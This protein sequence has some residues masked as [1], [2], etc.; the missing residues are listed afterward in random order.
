MAA[1]SRLYEAKLIRIDSGTETLTSTDLGRV[2]AKYYIDWQT[3]EKFAATLKPMMTDAELLEVFGMSKEFQQLKVREEEQGELE[4][5]WIDKQ[6]CPVQARGGASTIQGKVAIL[7]QA[8]I[9]NVGQFEATSLTSDLNYITQSASRLF[10]AMFD[11]TLTRTVRMSGLAEKVLEWCKC[12]DMRLWDPPYHHILRHF[13]QPPNIGNDR[14]AGYEAKKGGVLKDWAVQKLEERGF[15][16][17]RIRDDRMTEGELANV[18]GVPIAAQTVL[19]YVKRV[20]YLNTKVKLQPITGNIVRIV[21]QLTA[22]FEWSD[23]YS[24]FSEP[25]HIWVV[26]PSSEDL[27]HYETFVLTKKARNDLH[28]LSFIV[29]LNEPR[30]PQYIVQVVSDRWVGLT[31]EEAFKVSHLM[32]PDQDSQHTELLDLTPLPKRALKNPAYEAIYPRFTHFNAIQT[33][34]FHT[35]YHTDFNVLVG[36]PTGSGK[37]IISELAM[38]RLFNCTPTQ[39]VVYIA[40]LKAL[41]KERMIDWRDRLVKGL[42]KKVV[43]LTGDFTP[44]LK[45]LEEADVVV[46]T[47]EKFDGIS[48]NWKTRDYVKRTGLIIID[49]I[50]LLG[51]DRGPVL[52]VIVSRMRFMASQLSQPIR[53]VGLSTALANAPDIADW[54]GIGAVGL[55][56]FKPAV[57]PVPMTCH[58]QGYP[59]KHYCPRMATMN[60]PCLTAIKNHSA[61]KPVLI[62]VSSRR[63]TRITAFDLI[64]HM[65]QDDQMR[66]LVE[67]GNPPWIHMP[68]DEV[69]LWVDKAH[70]S[71]LKHCLGFGVGM[72]HAGLSENDRSLV[73][74]LFAC[75]KIQILIATSTLAWGVN[76][77]AH[78]VIV[79]GTEY[80]DGDTKRYVDMAITDVLQMIGRAGR[81]QFDDNAV[82]VVMVHEPKKAFYRKFLYS[83]FPVESS[84]HL[85]LADHLNAEIALGTVLDLKQAVQ[86]LSWTY[87]FRRLSANPSYY[88]CT[89][90]DS[91]REAM[92]KYFEA[93]LLDSLEQLRKSGCITMTAAHLA[94]GEVVPLTFASTYLGKI[95]ST[96]YLSHQS[97]RAFTRVMSSGTLAFAE[98]LKLLADCHEYRNV[99]VRHNEDKMNEELAQRVPLKVHNFESPHTK[100]LL[101]L[102]CHL[103]RLKLPIEDYQTDTKNIL[104]Q[105]IRVIQ[106]MIDVAALH[107]HAKTAENLILLLQCIQQAVH[108]WQDPL[109][110][111]PGL[112][113]ESIA[114]LS[115][116]TLASLVEDHY[117]PGLSRVSKGTAASVIDHVRKL[118][119]LSV[120]SSIQQARTVEVTLTLDNSP[121]E[122]AV[123]PK[124][125]KLKTVSW[126]VGLKSIDG[127]L[128]AIRK[129][130]MSSKKGTSRQVKID[131]VDDSSRAGLKVFVAPDSYV[132]LDQEMIVS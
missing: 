85:C 23:R 22:D 130:M 75:G 24:G 79:K 6:I 131:L 69:S 15:D 59:E 30:P 25:F 88:N 67:F 33:Q 101:L 113:S 104:D 122:Y 107:G 65:A 83:P 124:F 60:K 93:L 106:A 57:R 21:L 117:H 70:D 96:Y 10:R 20:P 100:A 51:A 129:V 97:V 80:Y 41:S 62:F 71:N 4:S 37:T 39:K 109:F 105:S 34:V 54:L 123:C 91:S 35:L 112:S 94:E 90:D 45:A 86:Y 28:E 95:A 18:L 9:S 50:H 29:P 47:P 72:H 36:A 5:M 26:D 73:E 102:Q 99:P 98:L 40:P 49:E 132:G 89:S 17:W 116:V 111:V 120:K 103:W 92:V 81:P 55:F 74:E 19:Y 66:Q 84:L 128:I 125:N 121:S 52:E 44:D 119:K 127:D 108:P 14:S 64:A 27:L 78:L 48:R 46:T 11:I 31:F 32:L 43:E 16:F 76:F 82:S 13:C 68:S 42:G 63:Q 126:W 56:N 87:L 118:P 110:T 1:A 115:P 12:V 53:F 77:P 7:L 3:A 8:Y 58:I 61:H 2:A 38:L 114:Q